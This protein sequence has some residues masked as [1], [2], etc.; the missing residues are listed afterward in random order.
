MW[1]TRPPPVNSNKIWFQLCTITLL[2]TPLTRTIFVPLGCSNKQ[3]LL[4]LVMIF[5]LSPYFQAVDKVL[6]FPDWFPKKIKDNVA[7]FKMALHTKF[8]FLVNKFL[9]SLSIVSDPKCFFLLHSP[10]NFNL[11]LKTKSFSLLSF[12]FDILQ[13]NNS[14]S[15][16]SAPSFKGSCQCKEVTV[17]LKLTAESTV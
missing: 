12:C 5:R 15:F 3:V 7:W 4:Y 9:T 13:L 11:I 14:G 2:E 17:L 16:L 1:L 10:E 6:F 8:T